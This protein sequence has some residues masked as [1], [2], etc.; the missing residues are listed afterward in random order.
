MEDAK[1]TSK[2][3]GKTNHI[4]IIYNFRP[5]LSVIMS[6]IISRY[7]TGVKADPDSEL[8]VRDECGLSDD[9][10]LTFPVLLVKFGWKSFYCCFVEGEINQR[11]M[12]GPASEMAT[13]V[14]LIDLSAMI[15]RDE[16]VFEKILISDF[17]V[18]ERIIEVFKAVDDESAIAFYSSPEEFRDIECEIMRVFNIE[19]EPVSMEDLCNARQ[20]H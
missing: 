13:V 12:T 3:T 16:L 2:E 17:P 5:I 11:K 15:A 18:E 7:I 19:D 20:V 4:R 8:T 6:K 1:F 14:A 9:Q 10:I